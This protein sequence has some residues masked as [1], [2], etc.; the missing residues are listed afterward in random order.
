MKL[1][2][3]TLREDETSDRNEYRDAIDQRWVEFLI[4]N[5]LVPVYMPN[6]I[7]AAKYLVEKIDFNGLIL[8][9]GNSIDSKE[10]DYSK[11]RNET[12]TFLLNWAIEKSIP[13][14]GV[15]RGMQFIQSFYGDVL[16]KVKD[17]VAMRHQIS[18]NH[19]VREVNSF[20]QFGTR[21]TN[22]IFEVIFRSN[23]GVIEQIL[24][25]EKKINGIMWHPEREDQF[26]KND[27]K[28]FKDTFNV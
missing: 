9:G 23:D 25:R 5:Q 27:L 4:E 8:S 3:L 17:H 11:K 18:G 21:E 19:V 16:V 14:L 20:H 13:V 7:N 24:S 22:P 12:E 1:V 10:S 2:A 26:D 28:L 15:C 6:N